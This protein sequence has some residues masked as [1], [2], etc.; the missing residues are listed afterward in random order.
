ML[1]YQTL[2]KGRF[3]LTGLLSAFGAFAL[4]AAWLA[5]NHYP[6]WTSFHGELAGFV[7]LG[8]F[9]LAALVDGNPITFDKTIAVFVAIGL[10]IGIQW[11]SGQI[12]YGGDAIV[13]C[14]YIAG[15]A[16][17]WWLGINSTRTAS[18][19]RVAVLLFA[20]ICVTSASIATFIALLQWLRLESSVWDV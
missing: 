10:L 8:L 18:Q 2:R 16:M 17:A 1:S 13:S 14:M 20:A 4:L 3:S 9:C 12:A 11:A 7:A 15:L 6:P 19:M 5:P